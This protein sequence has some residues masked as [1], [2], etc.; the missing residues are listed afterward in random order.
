[1]PQGAR[2]TGITAGAPAEKAKLRIG[3]VIVQFN[4]TRVEDDGHLVNLVALTA[5]GKEVK[6]EIFRDGKTFIVR[7]RV[8]DRSKFNAD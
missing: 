5:V 6:V 3:D 1:R 2:I 4:G 8:G 7:V